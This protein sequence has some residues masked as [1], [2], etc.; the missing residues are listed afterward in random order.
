MME[1]DEQ[2][3]ISWTG[4]YLEGVQKTPFLIQN[5]KIDSEGLFHGKGENHSGRYIVNGKLNGDGSFNF[6][7]ISNRSAP[8]KTF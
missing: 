1:L 6:N 3:P 5:M 2:N 4:F 7:L 8:K